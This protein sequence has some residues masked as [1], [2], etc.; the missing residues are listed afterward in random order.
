M[1][2]SGN[3]SSESLAFLRILMH[4]INFYCSESFVFHPA[5]NSHPPKLLDLITL[6]CYYG[7]K[8]TFTVMTVQSQLVFT[9]VNSWR[10]EEVTSESLRK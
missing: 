6:G 7:K 3:I 8:C 5:V 4:L 1:P 10:G 9:Y 2:A